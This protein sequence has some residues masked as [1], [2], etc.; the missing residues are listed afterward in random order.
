[1]TGS[2]FERIADCTRAISLKRDSS[3]GAF[4]RILKAFWTT[5]RNNFWRFSLIEYLEASASVSLSLVLNSNMI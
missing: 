5:F 1:M 4:M 2:L 3:A